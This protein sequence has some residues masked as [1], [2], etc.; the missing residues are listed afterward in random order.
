MSTR[1]RVSLLGVAALGLLIGSAAKTFAAPAR[2]DPSACGLAERT[3][4]VAAFDATPPRRI[5][6][7]LP[8]LA[9]SPE[10]EEVDGS[11]YVM[12][13]ADV[14]PPGGLGD[15]SATKPDV[16]HNAMCVVLPDGPV[17]YYNV[18]RQGFRA[19]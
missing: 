11:A 15:R 14:T 12:L 3:P 9:K 10:L 8:A 2:P 17:L 6:D 19:P 13:L 1:L 16:L 5:W 4:V 7:R 18:S